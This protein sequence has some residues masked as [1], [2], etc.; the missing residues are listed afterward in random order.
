MGMTGRNIDK[1]CGRSFD[2]SLCGHRIVRKRCVFIN[3]YHI[4]FEY[5]WAIKSICVRPDR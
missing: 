1:I 4:S 5:C 2:C 3:S